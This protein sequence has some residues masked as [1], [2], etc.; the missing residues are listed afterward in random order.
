MSET[1]KYYWLKLKRDFFKRHDTKIVESM[2]NGKDYLLFYMKLLVESIDHEGFLRFSDTIP[3]NDK[4]LATITDTNIDIVRSAVKVFSELEMMTQLDDGT[5]FM[6]QV[7]S[8]I[9]YETSDAIRMKIAREKKALLLIEQGECEQCSEVFKN[10]S[11]E[12]ELELEKEIDN[13]R[14]TK[15][16]PKDGTG[17]EH[18]ET[19]WKEY[20]RRVAKPQAMKKY[21]A[22]IRSGTTP[23]TI[24]ERL[25]IYKAQIKSLSTEAQF[26][27][28]PATFL[29]SLDDYLAIPEKS[30]DAP[31]VCVTMA[32]EMQAIIDKVYPR[33][34]P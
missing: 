4:M 32:P 6:D 25:E 22:L 15:G 19:F 11:P 13:T 31:I 8:M 21:N 20:P 7:Q 3:Y 24:L 2:E 16:Q 9:G 23:E 27:R 26:I 33:G 12:L 10:R 30:M 14:T 29:G 5:L 17:K 34:T 18:F 28:H 1:K